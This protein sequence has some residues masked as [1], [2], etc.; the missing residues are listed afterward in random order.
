MID[1]KTA[2]TQAPWT[3]NTYL[4]KVVEHLID[5]TVSGEDREYKTYVELYK[6]VLTDH[7][8]LVSSLVE[9]CVKDFSVVFAC[10]IGAGSEDDS[11]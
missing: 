5:S 6:Q 3:V 8:D 1:A 4:D 11:I 2:M 10:A 9:S 7:S